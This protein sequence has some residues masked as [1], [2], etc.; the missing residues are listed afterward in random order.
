MRESE[1]A[2]SLRDVIQLDL[3]YRQ[4]HPYDTHPPLRER[5]EAMR[6]V[7]PGAALAYD[8]AA[9]SLLHVHLEVG[10]RKALTR[11]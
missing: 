5:I 8:P 9:L 4:R 3:Q 2:K 7:N 1:V 10:E 6:D 11:Q